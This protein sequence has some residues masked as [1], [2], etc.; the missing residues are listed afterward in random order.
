M[1]RKE[2]EHQLAEIKANLRALL[3]LSTDFSGPGSIEYV[4]AVASAVSSVEHAEWRLERV[5]IQGEIRP[6][7]PV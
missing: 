3:R 7:V 4:Q 1:T 6:E 5:K 2:L